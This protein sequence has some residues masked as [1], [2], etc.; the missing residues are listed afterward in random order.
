MAL[1]AQ[2]AD[3]M[4]LVVGQAFSLALAGIAVGLAAAFGLMRYLTS[5]LFGVEPTDPLTFGLT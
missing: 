4:R 5:L 1:G 2:S 3:L